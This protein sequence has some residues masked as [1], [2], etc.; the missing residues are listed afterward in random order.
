[1]GQSDHAATHDHAPGSSRSPGVSTAGLATVWLRDS[2]KRRAL[3]IPVR[4]VSLV[5]RPAEQYGANVVGARPGPLT[6]KNPR[7]D[8]RLAPGEARTGTLA[9]AGC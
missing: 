9:A 8:G 5:W 4:Y 7:R 2:F 3:K 6:W 1:M